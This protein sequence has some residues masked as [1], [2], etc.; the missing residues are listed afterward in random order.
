LPLPSPVS[1]PAA[2]QAVHAAESVVRAGAVAGA[3][4]GEGIVAAEADA[5]FLL[6]AVFPVEIAAGEAA[7]EQ[8]RDLV[9]IDVQAVFDLLGAGEGADR[10]GLDGSFRCLARRRLAVAVGVRLRE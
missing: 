2:E 8:R 5:V 1:L 9:G 7:G 4:V 6:H 10:A 3:E